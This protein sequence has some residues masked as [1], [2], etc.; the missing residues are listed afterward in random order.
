[1]ATAAK[2]VERVAQNEYRVTWTLAAA[3]DDGDPFKCPPTLQAVVQLVSGTVGAGTTFFFDGTN[4]SVAATPPTP[5]GVTASPWAH[6]TNGTFGTTAAQ[7]VEDDDAAAISGTIG[8]GAFVVPSTPISTRRLPL[9][10]RP[11]MTGGTAAN[12][13]VVLLLSPLR[14]SL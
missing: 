7:C 5:P 3:G 13:K 2:L 8:A 14:G 6:E 12:I 10:V 9:W 11:R 1:M 4:D